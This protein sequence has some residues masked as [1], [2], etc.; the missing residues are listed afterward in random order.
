MENMERMHGN[1][2][3][4]EVFGRSILNKVSQSSNGSS[5]QP[6]ASSNPLPFTQHPPQEQ[7]SNPPPF[8]QYTSQQQ[9]TSSQPHNQYGEGQD[10]AQNTSAFVASSGASQPSYVPPPP[11]VPDPYADQNYVDYNVFSEFL[12]G[13]S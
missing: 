2:E 4:F 8:N 11:Q 1:L 7:T 9:T 5:A 6:Q 13:D 12:A 3:R 10:V